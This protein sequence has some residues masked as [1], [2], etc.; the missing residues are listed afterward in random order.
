[1]ESPSPDPTKAKRKRNKPA[2]DCGPALCRKLLAARRIQG[3]L[4]PEFRDIPTPISTDRKVF[5]Q[6][7]KQK[8]L[9]HSAFGQ[10]LEHI[11]ITFNPLLCRRNG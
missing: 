9:A 11:R 2:G 1:M 8:S 10:W 4:V 5:A 7:P 6:K 3:Y